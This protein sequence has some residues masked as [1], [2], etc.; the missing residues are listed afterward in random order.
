MVTVE[1]FLRALAVVESSDN[2]E[3]WGDHVVQADE[4]ARLGI[5]PDSPK[6]PKLAQAMGRWQVHPDRLV[7][8]AKRLDLWPTLGETYDHWV[9]R[10]LREIWADVTASTP[11]V[12]TAM[13]WHKQLTITDAD[14]RWDAKYAAKFNA[15]LLNAQEDLPG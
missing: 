13:Y 6:A 10:I 5:D 2:P 1:Q 15:A 7:F 11:E 8:E 9:E 14:P 3:A 12:E 4:C